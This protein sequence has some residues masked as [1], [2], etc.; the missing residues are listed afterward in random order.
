MK[1]LEAA[2]SEIEGPALLEPLFPQA[3]SWLGRHLPRTEPSHLGLRVPYCD[4]SALLRYFHGEKWSGHLTVREEGVLRH[5]LIYEG[6]VVAAASETCSGEQA[7][8]DLVEAYAAGA[9]ASAYPLAPK[10]AH[11]LSGVGSHIWRVPPNPEFTGILVE[12]GRSWFLV[13]GILLASLQLDHEESGLLPAP[14]RPQTLML[15]GTLAGWAHLSYALTLRG[16]DAL[17][18]ITTAAEELHRQGGKEASDLLAQL[19]RG[20]TPAEYAL[21][22]DRALGDLEP[23]LRGLVEG[24]YLLAGPGR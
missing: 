16:R 23:L 9:A 24:G 15:P 17:S 6:R 7:L 21:K 1:D 13:E 12:T 8:A 3:P 4:L 18:P 2:T 14:L 22:R 11:A 10:L 19:A 5:A 20:G